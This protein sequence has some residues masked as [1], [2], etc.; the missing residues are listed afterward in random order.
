MR[1]DRYDSGVN[2]R[3]YGS[4]VQITDTIIVILNNLSS[5]M[6]Q[7]AALLVE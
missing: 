7:I 2:I 5:V 4:E 3:T 1:H 6:F